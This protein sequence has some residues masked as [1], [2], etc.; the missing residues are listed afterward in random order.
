M[1]NAYRVVPGHVMLFRT[2]RS[3]LRPDQRKALD[4]LASKARTQD[5]KAHRS[6][7]R[8]KGR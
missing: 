6:A 7:K 1:A 4:M 5:R 2:L 3:A 8:T